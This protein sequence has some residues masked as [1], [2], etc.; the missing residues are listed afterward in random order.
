MKQLLDSVFVTSWITKISVGVIFPPYA[1]L[2]NL[3]AD[4]VQNAPP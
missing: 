4:F 1:N 2:Q 3:S